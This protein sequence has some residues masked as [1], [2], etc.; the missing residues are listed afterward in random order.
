MTTRVRADWLH[1]LVNQAQCIDDTTFSDAG[2]PSTL[3]AIE[4]RLMLALVPLTPIEKLLIRSVAAKAYVEALAL[5]QSVAAAAL[6]QRQGPEHAAHDFVRAEYPTRLTLAGLGRRLGHHPETLNRLFRKAFGLSIPKYLAE[7][8]VAEG[9]RR[10]RVGAEKV[11]SIALAVGYQSRRAFYRAV[12]RLTGL[13][14]GQLRAGQT[15]R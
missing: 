2:S 1:Q 15:S 6:L 10:L 13:T 12:H 11:E 7:V 14:P 9:V 3:R 4:Q 5:Q 8:R